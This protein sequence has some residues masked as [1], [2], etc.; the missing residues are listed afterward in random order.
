MPL[1]VQHV[2]RDDLPRILDIFCTSMSSI[3]LLV[4]TGDIPNLENLDEASAATAREHAIA[5]FAEILDSYP[6]VHFL[7]AVDAENGDIAAFAIW[8]FFS[9]PDGVADWKAYVETGDRLR[10]PVGCD[11]EAY[12]YG[13]SKIHEN[14][15]EVFGEGREHF[16]L[17]LLA[18]HPGHERRGAGSKLLNWA[19]EQADEKGLECHLEG[20]PTGYPLY[21]R[22]GFV[23]AFGKGNSL[24]DF[25]VSK[26]TGKEGDLVDL[27]AMVRPPQ[28]RSQR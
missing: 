9:G 10:V 16:H 4:A 6:K 5:R 23:D 25:D 3:S 21:S 22:K 1:S 15:Q 26:Y 17:G 28:K 18:T 7:K 20:T 19:L 24:L 12:R 27:T 8:Y 13:W 11:I 14:Y 2:Q